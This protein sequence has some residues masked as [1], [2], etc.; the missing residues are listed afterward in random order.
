MFTMD[1]NT[2]YIPVGPMGVPITG[3]I[4]ADAP[5]PPKQ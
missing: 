4:T 1:R 3:T 2:H 5:A